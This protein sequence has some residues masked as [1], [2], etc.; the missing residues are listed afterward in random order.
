VEEIDRY[1]LTERTLI[2][3]I[4]DYIFVS[5]KSEHWGKPLSYRAVYEVFHT[6]MKK[7]GVSFHFHALRHTFISALVE[8]GMDISVVRIIAGHRQITT[9]QQY[10]HISNRYLFESLNRYWSRCSSTG[11]V[12]GE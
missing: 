2:E 3:T 4:H 5:L 8:S 12:Q 7:A 10:T 1:I 11:G 6:A 9:T